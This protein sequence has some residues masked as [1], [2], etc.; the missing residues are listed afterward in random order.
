MDATHVV[1]L[2]LHALSMVVVLGYY[3]ILA[4]IVIPALARNLE[5]AALART[6]PAIE[7][8]ALPIMLLGIALF[9]VT[10]IYLLVKDGRYTGIGEFAS[11][12][13]TLMLV[14]HL[15]VVA[16]VVLGVGIDRLA[17]AVGNASDEGRKQTIDVL[18]LALDGM[19]ALGAIVLLLT[20]AAQ[21]S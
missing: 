3:G 2:W 11:T 13:S 21:L 9:V 17:A 8:R 15:V 12:W 10:G 14:K 6:I 7:R 4:R 19:T 20:A 5:G 18:V 16:M 1:A